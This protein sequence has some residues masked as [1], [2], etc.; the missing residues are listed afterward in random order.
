VCDKPDDSS[1]TVC[2]KPDDSSDTVCD[3]PD[4]SSDTVCDKPDD[5]S[6]TVCD[7]PDDSS[8]TVC[9]KPDDSSD[10]V[11]DKPDDS[12]DPCT[13]TYDSV[14]GLPNNTVT[15][16]TKV[17]SDGINKGANKSVELGSQEHS[18]IQRI[19]YTTDSVSSSFSSCHSNTY[20]A[21]WDRER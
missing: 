10:T 4:D 19:R 15:D 8:D 11:C 5:S 12:S 21:E 9:D 16:S 20:D 14:Q 7:K 13:S 6:D 18:R 17:K 1:D 3:K 2:D